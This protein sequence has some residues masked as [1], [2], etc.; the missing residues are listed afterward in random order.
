MPTWTFVIA[1]SL[2]PQ[3]VLVHDKEGAPSSTHR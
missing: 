2:S 3:I 1:T